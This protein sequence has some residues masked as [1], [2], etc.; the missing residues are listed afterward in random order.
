MAKTCLSVVLAA[1]EGTRMRSSLP[2]VLHKIGG[3]PL[4]GHVIRA[5]P[6]AAGDDIALI[7]GHGSAAVQA[8][9]RKWAP[10]AQFFEQSRRLGTAHA[11]LAA[12][13]LLGKTYDF[14]LITYGD[15][16]LIRPQAPEKARQML[17]QGADMVVSGFYA[18]K[19]HGYGRL[20]K[21]NGKLV[22]IVEEKEANA[23]EKAINLCNGGLLAVKGAHILPLLR[24]VENK[25][26]KGEYYL[27][28]I[29]ALAAARGLAVSIMELAEEDILGVNSQAD[30]AAAE[31]VW[32]KRKRLEMLERGVQCQAPETV[33]FSYD[34]EIAANVMI[35][36]HVFFGCGVKIAE[37]AQIR[38]FSH[39]EGAAIGKNAVIGPYARLRPGSRLGENVKIGNFCEIKQAAI[40]NGVKISH[41]TYM[42]DAEIGAG[43][44]IGAG[45]ISCNYNGR[46]KEK[47]T[48]GAGAFIGSDSVLVAPLNIGAGAY[49]AAGSTI[50]ADVESN[51]LAFG[52]ARQVNKADGARRLRA[53]P[54][55]KSQEKMR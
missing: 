12:E 33:Y 35:E 29:A 44:N 32:Q 1:G 5:L 47:L 46:S 39:I 24:A 2:K 40:G 21:K 36:P 8:E 34:T 49:I 18:D 20:V 26:A 51:A 22:K 25:N 4:I 52:R 15:T 6:A 9:A 23:A 37:G 38:A 54:A 53:V 50:T 45:A 41:L 14:V 7:T 19:P 10:K 11:A 17:R 31:A 55:G 30:L 16:P 13:K 27:T 3:L 43:S 42:G 48:I 28:D